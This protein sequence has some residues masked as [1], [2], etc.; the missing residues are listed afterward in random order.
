MSPIF[1]SLATLLSPSFLLV[2]AL[3]CS[4][5]EAGPPTSDVAGTPPWTTDENWFYELVDEDGEELGQAVLSVEIVDGETR[6]WQEFESDDAED[7]TIVTVESATLKPIAS[8]REI[9]QPDGDEERIEVEYTE[10]GALIRQGDDKQSGL[11]VPEHSYDNDTSLFLWRTLPF[12]EG[13]EGS[14]NT[15]ITNHRTRQKVNL[16]VTGRETVTVPAGTF[17]AWRLEITTSNA[18]QL[19][20]YA[21]TPQRQLVRYDN[22]RDVIFELE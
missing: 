2:T 12:A 3:A 9:R 1:R 6:L 5:G 21:D 10:E 18:R 13:Y 11:S 14:Y 8:E 20:W 4:S 7:T 17:E 22:D 16:R 15:I 19:A